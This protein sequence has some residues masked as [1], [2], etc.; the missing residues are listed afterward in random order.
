M[1]GKRLYI[2][3]NGFDI[4][5]DVKSR[6][7]DF[8]N[9]VEK[10]DHGLFEALEEYFNS[11]ELWSDFEETLAHIDTDKITDDA[12][13]FLEPYGADDWSD[14][15]HHDYQY[16]VQKAI[17]IVTITLKEQFTRWILNLE[18]PQL[19]KL[20]LAPTSIYLT[21]NYTDTL[22]RN[23]K[24]SPPQIV[25]IH[26]K[27]ISDTSTLILGHSRQPIPENALE[28]QEDWE[29]QDVRV[30]EGNRILDRYFIQ[31]YKNTEE[32]I[33]E[34]KYF[35]SQLFLINEVFVLG[36]SIS[37]VDLNY[38]QEVHKSVQKGCNWTVSFYAEA[39]KDKFEKALVSIGV[40]KNKISFTKLSDL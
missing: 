26:N 15:F 19:A 4:F 40:S 21:F 3:G 22:E 2:I 5:H 33:S 38:F 25:Y 14:A 10:N 29:D 1:S 8:K 9:Y 7:S 6:Y 13:D 27:A 20:N 35:F 18:I 36:H 39:E 12:S 11:D 30:M 23:Y 28:K 32:I 31:T 16:E 24:I 37:P 17:D 34:K